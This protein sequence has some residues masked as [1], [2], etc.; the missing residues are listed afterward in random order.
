MYL[1]IYSIKDTLDISYHIVIMTVDQLKNNET[2]LKRKCFTEVGPV[3]R[4]STDGRSK[5]DQ[6][7]CAIIAAEN[8]K[9]IIIQKLQKVV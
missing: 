7:C 2:M 4:S 5:T 6:K 1:R 3:A 8:L 9:V